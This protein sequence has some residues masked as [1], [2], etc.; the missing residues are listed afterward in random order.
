MEDCHEAKTPMD[1]NLQL[2][3]EDNAVDHTKHPY[4]E[5]IVCLMYIML[6][7]RH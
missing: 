6:T 5:L 4:K 3:K 1:A 7:S 2:N